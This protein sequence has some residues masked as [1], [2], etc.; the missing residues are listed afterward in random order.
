MK[1]VLISRYPR[2]YDKPKGGVESVTVNL[3]RALAKNDDLKVHLLTIERDISSEITEQDCNVSIHRLPGSYWPQ[4]LDVQTGPGKKKLLKKIGQLQPDIVHSHETY[5]LAMGNLDFPHVFTVHGF[6]H[7]N[8]PAQRGKFAMLRSCLWKEA[9]KKGLAKQKD[10]ISISPY[11]R[12]MIEPQTKANIYEIDNPINEHFFNLSGDKEPGRILCVGW[13]NERKNTLTSVKAFASALKRSKDGTLAIAGQAKDPVYMEKIQAVIR[14]AGI[15]EQVEFLGHI[16]HNKLAEELTKASILMLPSLQENAP[17]A[18]SEAM[19]AKLAVIT[20]NRCGMPYMV[21]QDKSG[22]L[23]EP[24]DIEQI[25]DRIAQLLNSP[26][27]CREFG[28]QGYKIAL[29]RFH[30]DVVAR[31]TCQVYEDILAAAG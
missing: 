29:E 11:V 6:D 24:E 28:E 1:I 21:E 4:L 8:I 12:D 23:I 19:A 18:I 27:L 2:S 3:A 5:G 14:E 7:A 30:P 10:I 15:S 25:A 13:I 26:Q 17:M 16:N 22:F 9:E 31:K 20:S